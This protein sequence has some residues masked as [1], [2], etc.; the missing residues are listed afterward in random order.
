M[1]NRH[2]VAR[3]HRAVAARSLLRTVATH[4]RMH[5]CICGAAYHAR[6]NSQHVKNNGAVEMK[7]ALWH[8]AINIKP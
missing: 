3:A 4:A 1:R 6:G 2:R 8:R 7:K 5:L